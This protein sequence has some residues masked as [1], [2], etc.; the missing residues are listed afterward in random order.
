MSALRE[1]DVDLVRATIRINNSRFGAVVVV[2]GSGRAS[3][4]A[5]FSLTAAPKEYSVGTILA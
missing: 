5:R 4:C 1:T 3:E 2:I